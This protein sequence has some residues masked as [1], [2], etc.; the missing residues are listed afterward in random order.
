[1]DNLEY[2]GYYGSVEYSKPD[3]CLVGEVFGMSRASI[4]YEGDTIDELEAD[5]QAGIESYLEGCEELG[6]EPEKTFNRVRP[7]S[8]SHV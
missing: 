1:M 3:N 8:L 7:M 6:I 4:T 5:F 2:K